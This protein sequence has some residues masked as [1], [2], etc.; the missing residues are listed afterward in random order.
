MSNISVKH[1]E[2]INNQFYIVSETYKL[3]GKSPFVTEF[4]KLDIQVKNPLKS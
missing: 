4:K 2:H 3:E 1:I